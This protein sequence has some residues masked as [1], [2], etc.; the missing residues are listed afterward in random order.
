MNTVW[1][2]TLVAG[3]ILLLGFLLWSF[4]INKNRL[5]PREDQAGEIGA[6]R[7]QDQLELERQRDEN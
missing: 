7:L 2:I 6:N 3:P 1:L 4:V 5:S